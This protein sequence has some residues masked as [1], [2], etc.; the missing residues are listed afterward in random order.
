ELSPTGRVSAPG[1]QV[2]AGSALLLPVAIANT[3]RFTGL[4]LDA[5]LQ[6]AATQPAALLGLPPR[7]TLAADWDAEKFRLTIRSITDAQE[8]SL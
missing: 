1:A 2:L 7:G 6:L 3:V 8:S 4:P 5:V